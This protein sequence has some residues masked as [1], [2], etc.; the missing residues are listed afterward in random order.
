MKNAHILQFYQQILGVVGRCKL[1]CLIMCEM[2]TLLLH[3]VLPA[4]WQHLCS[5]RYQNENS[6]LEI[7][8]GY[9]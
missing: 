6:P 8:S 1:F 2:F 5:R 7:H 4:Y 3:A 9:S